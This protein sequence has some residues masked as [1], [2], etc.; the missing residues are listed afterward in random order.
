MLVFGRLFMKTLTQKMSDDFVAKLKDHGVRQVEIAVN[1]Q[2]T[3]GQ[4]SK[5]FNGTKSFTLDAIVEIGLHYRI[6]IADILTKNVYKKV[7]KEIL[8]LFDKAEQ[9]AFE[10]NELVDKQTNKKAVS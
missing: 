3:Q 5:I 4:V 2:L 10:F 1:F 9:N 7:D 6:P 8:D